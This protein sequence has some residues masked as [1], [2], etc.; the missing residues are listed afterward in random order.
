M[1]VDGWDGAKV[2][3]AA[4]LDRR[5]ARRPPSSLSAACG[6]GDR[7]VWWARATLES[8]EAL[9]A[10]LRAG[11]VL[12]PLS[13]S[14]RAA[15]VA[16]VVGDAGPLSRSAT[17]TG[18]T[19]FGPGVDAWHMASWPTRPSARGRAVP[20]AAAG[21]RRAH[22]LHLGHHGKAQ[23]RRSHACVAPGRR[24]GAARGVGMGAG[25]PPRPVPPA[26]P[27][28]R[29]LCRPLR[30]PGRRRD[31][32]RLRSLRRDCDPR[33]R[34][35]EHAVLRRPDHVPPAGRVGTG[36]RARRAAP[37]RLGLGPLAADLWHRLAAEGVVVLERYGMTETL[38]TL[39]NPLV[40]ERRP[41][42]VGVPLPGVEAAVDDADEQGVG[43][44]LVRGESLCRGYWGR[45]ALEPGEWF[46]TGDLV[47]VADDGYVTVRGR[48]TELIIT[49]GHNVYPAEVEA[50]L[51]RHP[52]WS[53]WPWSVC[54]RRNGV[55]PWWPS[56]W[57]IPTW[58]RST[59][60]RRPSW[61]RSSAPA[62]CDSSTRCRAPRWARSCAGEL[63][64][65]NRIGQPDG[66]WSEV[67]PAV[68]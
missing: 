52:A 23:G 1:L 6:P 68:A 15:E 14:A 21:R 22:R 3:D 64:L 41:G 36:V 47:S 2:D 29:A 7:V 37:V 67:V 60:W 27:R 13:P 32:R 25:G 34:A 39:S 19:G 42:S 62:S 43:E 55:R 33:R 53:R 4:A 46:S 48:R 65:G 12:V 24:L 59:S 44:L 51:S 30:H 49:G 40:G 35:G 17:T 50:V 54:P 28:P 18:R 16:H 5:T 58:P 57:V 66:P 45:G 9:M 61:R 10:V 56:S 38:L 8:V 11:A 31:R 63:R 20:G 26:L